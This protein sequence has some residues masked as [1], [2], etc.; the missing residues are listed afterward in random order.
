MNYTKG[1]WSVRS[2]SVGSVIQSDNGDI[3]ILTIRAEDQ[4]NAHLIAAA[5]DMYETLK[6]TVA[7]MESLQTSDP[8]YALLC[9]LWLDDLKNAI[10]KAEDK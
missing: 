10:T 5:P 6:A 8:R 9:E 2:T 4:E 7:S 3:G 1:E